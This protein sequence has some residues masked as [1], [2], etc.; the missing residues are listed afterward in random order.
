MGDEEGAVV[1]TTGGVVVREERLAEEPVDLALTDTAVVVLVALPTTMN[2]PE[3]CPSSSSRPESRESAVAHAGNV[4][5][6]DEPAATAAPAEV[7]ESICG[8]A[9]RSDSSAS[10]GDAA[11]L[12]A[13][14]RDAVRFAVASSCWERHT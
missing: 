12:A 4:L 1:A 8:D 5:A 3:P 14:C 7:K 2:G 10:T 9:G 13:C 6:V 11:L